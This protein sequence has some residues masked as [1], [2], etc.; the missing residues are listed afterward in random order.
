MD[1]HPSTS[2]QARAEI[3]HA[4]PGA[5]VAG[6]GAAA[7]AA[8]GAALAAAVRAVAA[9][10]SSRRPLHPRGVLVRAV[11]ER[12]GS[13]DR[14]G[15]PWLDE[16]GTES[17][18]VR[19][20]RAVG[21]PRP[22]PDVIGL[23]LRVWPGG[24]G[25]GD[26][27]FSST[28]RGPLTRYLLRPTRRDDACLTSLMP[29][30]TPRGP[31]VLG[32]RRISPEE[33]VLVAAPGLGGQWRAVATVLLGEQVDDE[34]VDFDPVL[35]QVPG[36]ETYPWAARLRRPAYAVARASRGGDVDHPRD[37]PGQ[38]TGNSGSER[39]VVVPFPS[40]HRDDE[41]GGAEASAREVLSAEEL[42][43]EMSEESFPGSDPPSTWAG[44]DLGRR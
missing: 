32:A 7:S 42:A 41:L 18:L 16:P 10:R 34:E 19:V 13:S 43:D 40:R 28:G 26:L 21:L 1:E 38:T 4:G 9:V 30:R 36:L 35:H 29:F 37:L 17:G 27:L 3:V 2:S 44:P 39:D 5:G 24:G 25:P 33:V 11:V 22:L 23:A 12:L 15:V 6:G 20:S 31:V 8:A 14:L